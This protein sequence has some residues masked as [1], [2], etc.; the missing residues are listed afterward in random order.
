MNHKK[1]I[2]VEV[3]LKGNGQTQF[4]FVYLLNLLNYLSTYINFIFSK[5]VT[6]KEE[7]IFS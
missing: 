6:D 2:T 4:N 1:A 3:W 7:K 5:A